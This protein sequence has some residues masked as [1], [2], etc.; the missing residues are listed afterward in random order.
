MRTAPKE[1]GP[2]SETPRSLRNAA[3]FHDGPTD[4]KLVGLFSILAV[5]GSI[6]GN[7]LAARLPV[8][9]LRQ[10]FAAMVLVTGGW[11]MWQNLAA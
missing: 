6:A 5:V 7:R 8:K 4:W 10:G 1:K 3:H 2:P 9:R 11:V